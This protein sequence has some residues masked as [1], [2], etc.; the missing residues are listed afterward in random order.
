MGDESF[1]RYAD[2]SLPTTTTTKNLVA[3]V[4][5]DE[6]EPVGARTGEAGS[7]VAGAGSEPSPGQG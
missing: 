7:A 2:G 4:A 3:F 6:P 5:V 1:P